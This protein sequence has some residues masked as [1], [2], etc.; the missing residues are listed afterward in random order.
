MGVIV[1]NAWKLS[2]DVPAGQVQEAL[3]NV[4]LDLT[5][6]SRNVLGDLEK[7]IKK[8]RRVLEEF[9]RG[10]SL[11]LLRVGLIC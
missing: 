4:A 9:R 3:H 5:D 10:Q 2:M 1:E 8:A 6:W 7:R 11:V